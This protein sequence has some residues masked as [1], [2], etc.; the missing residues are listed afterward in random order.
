MTRIAQCCEVHILY[1]SVRQNAPEGRAGRTA[2]T[3][4]SRDGLG[5]RPNVPHHE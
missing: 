1:A 3:L 4:F 5:S 2:Y